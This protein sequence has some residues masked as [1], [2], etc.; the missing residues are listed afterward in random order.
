LV[1]GSSSTVGLDHSRK[2]DKG[3]IYGGQ[4]KEAKADSIHN[5]SIF[6]N[7]AGPGNP[8]IRVESWLKRAAP[9][10][11]GS[12]AFEVQCEQGRKGN[13]HIVGLIPAQD[14]EEA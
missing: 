2:Y 6:L 5:L 10:G 13:W 3:I 1:L 8:I 9:Q 12:F 7:K 4:D 14:P 11:E